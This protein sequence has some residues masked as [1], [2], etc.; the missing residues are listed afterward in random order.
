[1]ATLAHDA[2]YA[3]LAITG[4]PIQPDYNQPIDQLYL[5]VAKLGVQC[6]R[7][8]VLLYCAAK[9]EG[10]NPSAHTPSWVAEWLA[11]KQE[12]AG[13]FLERFLDIY[14][15]NAQFSASK[16][17]IVDENGHLIL[18][19]KVYDFIHHTGP[20]SK[21]FG[22][23]GQV[24]DISRHY[25]PTERYVTGIPPLQAVLR[26]ILCDHDGRGLRLHT[27]ARR[28]HDIFMRVVILAL[29]GDLQSISDQ[30]KG[31]ALG[32]NSLL[33]MPTGENF[34]ESYANRQP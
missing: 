3:F 30:S 9:I 13:A 20:I 19:G 7:L 15:A 25:K 27:T 26:T 29:A 12:C 23:S 34:A 22:I 4:L 28:N 16:S 21:P 5:S 6:K 33:G 11:T 8:E 18:T 32:L 17:P 1:M 10:D 24:V 2:I 14:N 31:T